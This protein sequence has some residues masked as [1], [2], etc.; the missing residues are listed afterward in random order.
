MSEQSQLE[1]AIQA[2]LHDCQGST[3]ALSGS[4]KYEL[5]FSESESDD[6][7]VSLNSDTK[8]DMDETD[9]R[10]VDNTDIYLRNGNHA[11][12]HTS[13]EGAAF[14]DRP[15]LDTTDAD[16]KVRETPTDIQP[17][18]SIDEEETRAEQTLSRKRSLSQSSIDGEYPQKVRRGS[19]SK[20]SNYSLEWS[21]KAKSKLV[22]NF[23]DEQRSPKLAQSS[24]AEFNSDSTNSVEALLVS[25]M[26]ENDQVSHILFRLPDGSRL[27]KAFI[28]L[29][30]IKVM[31]TFSM[32]KCCPE[33][34]LIV[35]ICAC[36]GVV[37]LLGG[38]GPR[39]E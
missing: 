29:H 23:N 9:K 39:Y 17:L 20:A 7:L 28:C 13:S 27:Q 36:V 31:R 8:S 21:Q 18:L 22:K 12:V 25:G 37:R 26:I 2:S 4:S 16:S 34:C 3:N 14:I 11:R 30:P 1:A 24:G 5:V 35:S 32:S 38:A 33:S 6:D 19:R 15:V 10:W